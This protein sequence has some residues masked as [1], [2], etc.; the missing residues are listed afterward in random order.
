MEA[1]IF[2]GVQATGKT[3]FYAQHFLK[4]HIR[5]S[6]DMLHTRNKE[7]RIMQACLEVQHP[8]V[9]DNTNPTREDRAK[10]IAEARA[11]K[12]KVTGY[13]FQSKLEEALLRNNT[14]TGKELIVEKGIR[15]TYSKLELPD[16]SEGFDALYYVNITEQG[17]HIKNWDHEI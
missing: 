1:I 5:I 15:A 17:F 14:R 10:Y 8:F 13:Y 9:I 6:M 2:C 16:L 12:Y 7:S 3:T 11:R 4:T